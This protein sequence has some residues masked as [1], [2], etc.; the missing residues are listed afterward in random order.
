MSK[1]KALFQ[2]SIKALVMNN[3]GEVLVLRHALRDVNK[4]KY[5]LPGGRFDDDELSVDF[6]DILKREIVE[7][8]GDVVVAIKPKPVA[9]DKHTFHD[10]GLSVLYIFFE[11]DYLSGEIVISSEH[12][13]YEWIKLEEVNPEEC[14]GN[15]LIDGVR[16]YLNK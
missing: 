12:S 5:D 6:I 15:F 10:S 9:V 14:F 11:A 1:E 7:E 4:G 3:K 2:L 8:L 16:M 13:G